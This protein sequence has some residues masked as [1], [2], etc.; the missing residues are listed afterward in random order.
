MNTQT[1]AFLIIA[2][3]TV[4]SAVA[5]VTTRHVVRSALYLA[6]CFVLLAILYFTMNLHLIGISQ[7]LVY[8]GL[9]MM[10]F[11]FCILLLNLSSPGMLIE[12]RPFTIWV[13]FLFAGGLVMI[14]F[15]QVIGPLVIS[16][17]PTSPDDYGTAKAVGSVLFTN[18]V[19]AF[20]ISSVLLLIGIVGSILLAK[21]RN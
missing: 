12:T 10:L 20:E 11:L 17:A 9:V 8:T 18:W 14:V 16:T 5:M 1:I 4:L 13:A 2:G 21:R 7:V 6:A 19:Y 3:L 15:S